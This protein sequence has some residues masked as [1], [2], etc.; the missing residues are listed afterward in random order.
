MLPRR[1]GL[2]PALDYARINR[3]RLWCLPRRVQLPAQ[4]LI[5]GSQFVIGRHR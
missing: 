4:S 5:L 3:S 2:L 1:R